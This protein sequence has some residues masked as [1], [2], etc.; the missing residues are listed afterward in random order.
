[1]GTPGIQ[2]AK[3]VGKGMKVD[4]W[5]KAGKKENQLNRIKSIGEWIEEIQHKGR[6][7]I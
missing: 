2:D 3:F 6:I 4:F 5:W 1:M 7:K